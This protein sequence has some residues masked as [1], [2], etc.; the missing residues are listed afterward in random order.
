MISKKRETILIVE[1]DIGVARLQRRRLER[2]GYTTE[3]VTTGAEALSRISRGGV[4]LI[5]LDFR[6]PDNMTGLDVHAKLKDTGEDI[7]VILV[8]GFS[9]EQIAIQALRAGVRDFVSKSVEYLEYLPQA[10]E[11]VLEEIRT[12]NALTQSERRFQAFMDNSPAV[13]FLKDE[14][15]R[16]VYANKVFERAYQLTRD[17]WFQRSDS[18]LWPQDIAQ[19]LR[20]ND[21]RVLEEQG[22]L[23][24][25]EQLPSPREGK[26]QQWLTFKFPVQDADGERFVGGMAVDV[27]E[28]IEA[29][30]SLR[31]VQ[32]QLQQAQKMEAVGRLA[33][34]VAHDFNNLLTVILGYSN[35][36]LGDLGPQH[37]LRAEIEE[38][39]HA[40]Q[41]SSALTRQLLTF[42]RQQVFDPQVI[43][44]NSVV[45]NVEKLLRRLIGDDVLLQTSLNAEHGRILADVGQI[46]QVIVN[47]AVNARDA[48]PDGGRLIV[49]TAEVECDEAFSTVHLNVRPGRYVM[50]AVSDSGQG[51]D[52]ETQSRIFEPFFTTK[53]PGQGTGLGLSTVYGIVSQGG[54]HTFVQSA[55]GQGT[56]FRVYFPVAT[57]AVEVPTVA[58]PASHKMTGSELVLLVDDHEGV[59]SLT[60]QV[61]SEH[62][63][64][65]LQASDPAEA[66]SCAAHCERP[67]DLLLTDV[68][69]L[70]RS[71]PEL[72]DRLR[73]VWPDLKVLFMSGYAGDLLLQRQFDARREPFLQ[74]P[75][76]A[77]TLLRSVR[78]VLDGSL[79]RTSAAMGERPRDLVG[80]A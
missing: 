27:T 48:M 10:V 8:T 1:D 9:D 11:R 41:R 36:I 55:R 38:I 7:P 24:V 32:G 39:H 44:L 62:G 25:V 47:L 68:V 46:E 49:E 19:S 52:Q 67:V 42:S 78:T 53:A 20:E 58:K 69:M 6:L 63:Y 40:A 16:M 74:K 22:T 17:D 76:N 54:G 77:E 79:A 23:E 80:R 12:R 14:A 33:G 2:V 50:L 3:T 18:E 45:V 65:V 28:R 64:Q 29:E 26:V 30:K 21:L 71:G 57:E 75:F 43:D 61:L 34:G 59:R 31:S 5:I 70:G 66:I 15:G 37:P 72:A 13:A 35:I 4:D 73:T 56:T 51:M 60:R